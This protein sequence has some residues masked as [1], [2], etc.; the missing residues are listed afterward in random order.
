MDE[1]KKQR[2]FEEEFLPHLDALYHFALS[3][4]RNKHDAEDLVQ[5]VFL[6]AYNNLDKYKQGT[7]AK[8]WLFT[9]MRNYF[10]NKYKKNKKD[11]LSTAT[12]N[13]KNIEEKE[14][15]AETPLLSDSLSAIV[16]DALMELSEEFRTI[17]YLIDIEGLK[18]EEVSEIMNVPIGTIRSRLHRARAKL[19][20]KLERYAYDLGYITETK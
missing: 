15:N 7:N 8:A 6:R 16:N 2:F 17:V 1:R 19:R 12:A 18:Y 5:E 3:L 20:K 9:M 4:T 13:E 10:I 11:I 14:E